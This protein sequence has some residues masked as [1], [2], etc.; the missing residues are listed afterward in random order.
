[1]MRTPS[2]PLRRGT[3]AALLVLATLASSAHI[4]ENNAYFRG[5]AG[6]YPVQ[7]TVRHP[8]V[9]PGLADIIVRVDGS[10]VHEVAVRPVKNT[11]GIE[12]APRPDIARPVTGSA[13]LYTAQLWFMERG[14]YSVHVSVRGD[15]GEG[16]VIVPVNSVATERLELSTTLALVLIGLGLFLSIGLISI[17]RGAVRESVLAPGASPTPALVR[18]G[19]IASVAT[20]AVVALILWGGARWWDAEDAMYERA[21]WQPFTI[22]TR[23]NAEGDARVLALAVTDERWTER[24]VSPLIPDHGKLMHMFL[25]RLPDMDAFAHVHPVTEDADTFHLVLP[26]L[27]E[28]RYAV[29]ADVVHESGLAHTMHDTVFIPAAVALAGRSGDP[30]DSWWPENQ[31]GRL[32][33]TSRDTVQLADGSFLVWDRPARIVADRL[34][35]LRFT[36][37]EAD[38]AAARLEYYMG[39]LS[40]AA[41][42]RDDGS[43]FVHLHPTGS[44]AMAAQERL[45]EQ[46]MGGT[47]ADG[48]H[49]AHRHG[50]HELPVAA[51]PGAITIPYAF[52]RAG[53]YRLWVQVRRAGMVHT[54]AWDVEVAER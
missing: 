42:R 5:S 15:A 22:D 52:P 47:G 16:I 34:L 54:A 45:T 17:V 25:V 20:V 35:E 36:P 33:A 8:G 7:V 13:G 28:G 32:Q 40:H 23:V 4:G 51:V 46:M 9:V 1:M 6:P 26:P 30:E 38:G 24:R 53:R 49:D 48:G 14:A 44:I 11:M 2:S 12:S 41:I 43:V 27:P 10:A 37:L 31:Q 50:A 19:R 39:M 29:Y 21:M 3:H 18:R